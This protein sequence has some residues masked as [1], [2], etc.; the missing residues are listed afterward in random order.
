[1]DATPNEDYPLRILRAKRQHCDCNWT[2]NTDGALPK[3]LLLKLMNEQN[4]Q[5]AE[6]LDRAIAKLLKRK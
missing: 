5:R 1:M 6:I 2:D 3:N 4:A